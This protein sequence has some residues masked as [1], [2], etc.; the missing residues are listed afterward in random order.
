MDPGLELEILRGVVDASSDAC[1]CMEFGVPVDLAAPYDEIVRQ[2]FENN[3]YWS[4]ANA[5]MSRLYLLEP[6]EDFLKR[7][8]AEIFPRNKQNEDFVLNLLANGF[9]VDGAPARDTRYDG[10]QIYVEND[11]RA[12]I[13][14]GKLRRLFG[15][16]RD[17][18]KHHRREENL[19]NERDEA[20]DIL[21]AL[22]QPVLALNSDS[23]V[24]A[25]SRS[26]ELLLRAGADD[27]LG[28][29][30]AELEI[31][32]L[33]EAVTQSGEQMMPTEGANGQISWAIAPR[34]MGGVVVTLELVAQE[35]S[36]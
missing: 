6:N 19:R 5:A 4:I 29:P 12:H 33:S 35:G 1:W 11:V 8:T 15:I 21:A 3:P 24:I 25:V 28:V 32:G 30:V 9:E 22:P 31:V 26:A 2:V 7:P 23:V 13:A 16:V 14:D 17:V 34:R 10:V 18:E 27:L 36:L 20:L